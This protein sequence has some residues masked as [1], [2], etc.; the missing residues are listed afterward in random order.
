MGVLLDRV[1]K[2]WIEG[3]LNKSICSIALID[4]R[5]ETQ[6]EAVAHAWDQILEL[7]DQS[8][9]TLSPQKKISQIFDELNR[10]L[11]ILGEPGSG[12]TTTLLQLTRDLIEQARGILNSASQSR[13]C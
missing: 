7:P 8:R 3:V 1:E 13:L 10:G 5:K 11:L 6:A 4:L 12:K 2:F 9:Q